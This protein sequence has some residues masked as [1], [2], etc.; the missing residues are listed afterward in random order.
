M[1]ELGE[2]LS[3][4]REYWKA[5]EKYVEE[6]F[7]SN[8]IEL[9][10]CEERLSKADVWERYEILWRVDILLYPIL[11]VLQD[12]SYRTK[13]LSE[14][15]SDTYLK[16]TRRLPNVIQTLASWM[17][18]PEK[19]P[20][21]TNLL[22][23]PISHLVLFLIRENQTKY[24]FQQLQQYIEKHIGQI[25]SSETM[26]FA[27]NHGTQLTFNF[28]KLF[29]P[30]KA[31]AFSGITSERIRKYNTKTL[32]ASSTGVALDDSHGVSSD[33]S[34]GVSN[35]NQGDNSHGVSHQVSS[36]PTDYFDK[37]RQQHVIMFDPLYNLHV[38]QYSEY[39]SVTP[40]SEF[41]QKKAADN[42]MKD[43]PK[44]REHLYSDSFKKKIRDA[45]A[46]STSS[47]IDDS[48]G[49]LSR[50][51]SSSVTHEKT[52]LTEIVRIEELSSLVYRE[53]MKKYK[54]VDPEDKRYMD[55]IR[56]YLLAGMKETNS[57]LWTNYEPS[58][59]KFLQDK[60]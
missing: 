55:I 7:S 43:L 56:G 20:E 19:L 22:Q 49:D 26:I 6:D 48:T 51:T 13:L 30:Q 21:A 17:T 29:V 25:L 38:N 50:D 5:V 59:R 58:Y 54:N 39:H 8:F 3:Y 35:S 24:S 10:E 14:M 27:F 28:D 12:D 60:K 1:S 52:D 4:V 15:S 31:N 33:N 46:I 34:H 41:L 37:L 47:A 45:I 32:N 16:L 18:L 36:K 42:I 40:S 9:S 44:N 11:Y 53:F 57:N 2:I 23:R